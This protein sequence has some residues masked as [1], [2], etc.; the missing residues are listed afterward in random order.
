[1]DDFCNLTC[2]MVS[3][4]R[5][6]SRNRCIHTYS[7]SAGFGG[8]ADSVDRRPEIGRVSRVSGDGRRV[9]NRGPRRAVFACWG[10]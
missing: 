5:E 9:S 4:F 7:A 2:P 8:F 6:F 3:R 1:M 10:E